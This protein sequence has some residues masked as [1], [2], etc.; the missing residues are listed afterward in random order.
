MQAHSLLEFTA[1]QFQSSKHHVNSTNLHSSNF[2]VTECIVD[3]D[4]VYKLWSSQKDRWQKVQ[5]YCII[6]TLLFDVICNRLV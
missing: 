6:A 3:L 5:D 2:V 4:K 1:Q